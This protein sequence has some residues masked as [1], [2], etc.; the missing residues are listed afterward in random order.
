MASSLDV[1]IR[2]G[3]LCGPGGS[4]R[5]VNIEGG[6]GGARRVAT[7]LDWGV[8]KTA[9]RNKNV[10]PGGGRQSPNKPHERRAMS[11]LPDAMHALNII[12]YPQKATLYITFISSVV[13]WG[14][15]RRVMAAGIIWS[16]LMA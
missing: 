5:E 9:S 13:Y 3:G 11:I 10:T 12:R 2:E 4:G 8:G 7:R 6:R 1:R 14:C 15:S 16:F